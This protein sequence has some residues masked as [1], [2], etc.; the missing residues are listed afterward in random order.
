MSNDTIPAFS[1][2]LKTA[3]SAQLAPNA[4]SFVDM[5][6]ERG[7][8]EFPFAPEG[9]VRRIEGRAALIAYLADLG[10]LVGIANVSV[11]TVHRTTD[12]GTVILE[13][14]S[15]G[16][17]IATGRAYRQTYISVIKLV[18]GRI[19]HYRDYWNPLVIRELMADTGVGAVISDAR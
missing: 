7:V 9:G 17:S 4:A 1:A 10:A 19:V 5:F 6:D 8:M 15:A 11:P 13:F 14:E 2:M 16:T 12:S 3:L 18:A